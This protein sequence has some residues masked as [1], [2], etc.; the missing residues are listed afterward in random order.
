MNARSS[1]VSLLS[2][3]P[4][5]LAIASFAVTVVGKWY[6]RAFASKGCVGRGGR[7]G[8][9][10]VGGVTDAV[11][12]LFAFAALERPVPMKRNRPGHRGVGAR[13][14]T[15]VFDV[16]GLVKQAP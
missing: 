4:N 11:G 6:S 3:R 10:T 5:S 9:G 1:G 14:L 13:T 16:E 2:G 15:L 8:G 12:A 7:L